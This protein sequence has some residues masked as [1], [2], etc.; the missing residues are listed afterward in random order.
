MWKTRVLLS[1]A[2]LTLAGSSLT[3]RADGELT[4]GAICCEYSNPDCA[5][6][7]FP[8]CNMVGADC[9]PEKPG[10]QGYCMADENNL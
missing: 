1:L 2:V 3:L 7:S 4:E 8:Q 5:G 6:T 9:S 10:N